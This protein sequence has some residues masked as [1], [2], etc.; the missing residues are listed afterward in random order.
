MQGISINRCLLAVFVAVI[1]LLFASGCMSG[2]KLR[3]QQEQ[4][5][6]QIED[7]RNRAYRCTPKELAL[8]ESHAEFAEWELSQGNLRRAKEHLLYSAKY[9]EQADLESRA[10]ECQDVQVVVASD[11][12]GDGYLDEVD[13]CPDQP[14]DFDGDRDEDGCPDIELDKDGDGILDN[15]DRC[16]LDPEDFDGFEDI[17]GCPDADNDKDKICDPWVAEKGLLDKFECKLSDQCPDDPED[18]DGFQDEDGCPDIDND[19]DKIPDVADT[20]PNDP[21]DY[22]N[23]E[24][25]DGCPEERTLIVLKKDKIELKEPVYFATNKTKVL[26][27]SEPLLDEIASLLSSNPTI[28]VRIEG[29]TDSEG[30]NKS[31]QKLSDGRANSVRTELIS[32]GID[33]SRMVA[34]GYGEDRPIDTND[35]KEGRANNRRVDFVITSNTD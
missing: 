16:P 1:G 10:Q 31:N 22:D 27:R 15:D 32:R 21:E 12:D 25:S 13:Q 4:I 35:T 14:E 2:T 34:V 6:K 26:P 30:K 24:D 20:C 11:R 33:A 18:M 7:M 19:N 5:V 29:H 28:T 23:D 9:S 3:V 17:E 8:A